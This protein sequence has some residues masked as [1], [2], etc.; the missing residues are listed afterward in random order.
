MVSGKYPGTQATWVN[1]REEDMKAGKVG[2]ET[3][4]RLKG[5]LWTLSRW[6]RQPLWRAEGLFADTDLNASQ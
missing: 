6:L 4:T 3:Q 2:G 5:T 1:S